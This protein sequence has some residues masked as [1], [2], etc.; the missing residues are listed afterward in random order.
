[1]VNEL[2]TDKSRTVEILI[3]NLS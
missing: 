2:A 3:L 1:L